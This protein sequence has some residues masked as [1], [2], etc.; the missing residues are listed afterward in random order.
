[1]KF[2]V[3]LKLNYKS[4]EWFQFKWEK[5]LDLMIEEF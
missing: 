5:R 3:R 2:L 4:N 1:M